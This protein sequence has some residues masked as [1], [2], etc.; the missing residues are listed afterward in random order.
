MA[1]RVT[2][3][4][5]RFNK[6]TPQQFFASMLRFWDS[7]IQNEPEYQR[8]TRK[9]DEWLRRVW[10]KE[11]YLAGVVNSVVQIDKNRGF[12]ITGGRN[13]VRRYSNMLHNRMYFSPDLSGWRATFG[14]L[15]L[16]YYTSDLG[17]VVENGRDG[18]DGPLDSLYFTDP[19]R[20]AL[21]GR[22]DYPLTYYPTNGYRGQEWASADYF[23][24]VSMPSTDEQLAGLGLCAVSRCIELVKIMV[25]I[26]QYDNEM[27]LNRAPRGLL[28]LKGIT[29]TQWTDAMTARDA[30]LVGDELKYYASL[31]VLAANDPGV[32]LDAKLIALSQLPAQ[33]DQKTFTDLLIYGY[34]L[35]FG[36][37]PREFW[38]VSSGA[39]GTATETEMGHRKAGS[40]GGLDFCLGFQEK[41]NS[42]NEL[43]PTV[44]FEFQERD[45]DG[46]LAEAQLTSAKVAPV[47]AMFK[48]GLITLEEA[49]TLLAQQNIIDPAWTLPEEDVTVSDTGEGDVDRLLKTEQVQRAMFTFPNEPIVKISY[50]N[51]KTKEVV[52][53]PPGQ[54][55]RAFYSLPQ[56]IVTRQAAID[57]DLVTYQEYINDLASEANGG[58][59]DQDEFEEELAGSTLAIL[60]LALLLGS[61]NKSEAAQELIDAARAVLAGDITEV[62]TLNDDDLLGAALTDD[63]RKA[64]DTEVSGSNDSTLGADIYAGKYIDN[65]GGLLTRL[66]LWGSTAL[67]LFGVGE[68]FG[69]PERMKKWLWGNTEKPCVTCLRLNGQVHTSG[70]WARSGWYPKSRHLDC[71]GYNCACSLVDTDEP[72]NGDF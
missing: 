69:K 65:A 25:G 61:E 55:K 28:L 52:I 16:S 22:M 47:D 3:K 46:E 15:S 66:G 38:P 29:D 2:S 27:L 17:A 43:P 23:R 53:T 59:I 6:V 4:Q 8:D 7:D 60:L 24:I 41:L 62:D 44:L 39:L 54:L 11:P 12:D 5:P 72:E 21:T 30:K 42:D 68:L 51:G 32:E 63:E 67:M 26:Y 40:K 34:A 48:A 37:D 14:G 36:Y 45:Q 1:K 18:K 57:D 64:L 49:R 13:Q 19:A 56:R 31:A 10:P 33:F 58:D 9:R 20:C 71:R 50:A 70:D 35:T